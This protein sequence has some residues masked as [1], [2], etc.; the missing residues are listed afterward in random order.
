MRVCEILTEAKTYTIL[1]RKQISSQEWLGVY[2]LHDNTILHVT[3]KPPYRDGD[4]YVSADVGTAEDNL[5]HIGY[6]LYHPKTKAVEEVDVDEEYRRCGVATVMYDQLVALGYKVRPAKVQE[7]DGKLFWADRKT[8]RK[9][10]G[11]FTPTEGC[12]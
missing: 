7:I 3:V 10:V 6:C 9:S 1:S 11:V 4:I 5:K 8:R 12:S 2:R